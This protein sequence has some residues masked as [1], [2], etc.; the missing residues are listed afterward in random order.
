MY[1][2]NRATVIRVSEA[3]GSTRPAGSART[4]IRSPCGASGG[5]HRRSMENTM[6]SSSDSQNSG[7]E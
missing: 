6:T 5:N 1:R 2:L 4:C 7:I 3:T